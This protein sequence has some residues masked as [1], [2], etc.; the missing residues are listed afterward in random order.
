MMEGAIQDSESEWSSRDDASDTSSVLDFDVE[1]DPELDDID[2]PPRPA[3]RFRRVGVY[4][5]A[6]DAEQSMESFN[7]F[8][9]TYD[10]RYE[11]ERLHVRL[12]T[13]RSHLLCRHRIKIRCVEDEDRDDEYVVEEGGD[14]TDTI[15]A[16]RRRGIHP[17]LR[18]EVDPMLRMGWSAGRLRSLL[19][20]RYAGQERVISMIQLP[21]RSRIAGRTWFGRHT[22]AG[23][24]PPTHVITRITRNI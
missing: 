11:T 6:A 19:L 23:K 16:A 18:A 3:V 12:F 5:T 1:R 14:L 7:E 10:T 22:A 4:A 21:G 9:Y 17:A 2:P 8:V 24:S 15:V 13:C 20:Q